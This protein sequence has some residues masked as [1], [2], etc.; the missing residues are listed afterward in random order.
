MDVQC[1]LCPKGCVIPPG[2]SGDCRIRVNLEGKL[3]AV[4]YGFPSSV[5]IDPVEKKPLH[6]FLPGTDILSIATVGC[7]LHC[8][9]CQNWELSQQDPE[10]SAAAWLPPTEVAA[11]ARRYECP[12]VAYTY[13]DPS[14]Y[15]EYAYDS[16]IA[17]REAGLRNVMVT[18]GYLNQK[19]VRDLYRFVDAANI[20]LKALSDRFYRDVCDA[21]L[22]PVLNTL[23]ITKSM[24]VEVEVTNLVIPTLND[25][26]EDLRALCR[27]VA[28]NLGKETPL[29]FSRFHPHYRMRHLPPTPE[30]TL[31]RAREIAQ[32]EGLHFVYVGN[33]TMKDASNTFCPNCRAVLVRRVGYKILE[34]HLANGACEFCG[35]RIYG[36]WT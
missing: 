10:E 23:V 32:A 15:Y 18:A 17:C 6:H 30:S 9:N 8:K 33:L 4:T 21:T 1:D 16:C 29:H 19:P 34:N 28:E 25:R 12:S 5:H 20:D 26:D 7:N 31:A 13:S 11:L 35:T 3:R 14:A 27:W 24:G 22:Q 36:I 2:H